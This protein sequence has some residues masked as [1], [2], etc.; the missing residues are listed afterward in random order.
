M[1]PE[2]RRMIQAIRESEIEHAAKTGRPILYSDKPIDVVGEYPQ[3]KQAQ[4]SDVPAA[5]NKNT[6]AMAALSQ[7][8]PQSNNA[9]G[10]A[11]G[12]LTTMGAASGNPYL[13]G[14][15]LG[16]QVLG[17]NQARRDRER[18][19]EAEMRNARIVRQQTALQSLMQMSQGMG[20]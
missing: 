9:M 7:S 13:L 5:T 4:A 17:A 6:A 1:T 8:A 14:A 10:T 3:G 19:Q 11:G 15:G 12:G 20:V 16:L 18:Q 2:E